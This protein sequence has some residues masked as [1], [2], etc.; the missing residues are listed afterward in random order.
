MEKMRGILFVSKMVWGLASIWKRRF[1]IARVVFYLGCGGWALGIINDM[2]VCCVGIF[3]NVKNTCLQKIPTISEP[4]L[5][6]VF[7]SSCRSHYAVSPF[8]VCLSNNYSRRHQSETAISTKLGTGE[9]CRAK[10]PQCDYPK[11]LHIKKSYM[12]VPTN[13]AAQRD[14]ETI[15]HEMLF[16]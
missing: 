16:H 1:R 10:I 8:C 2:F 9:R 13:N 4:M 12:H 3:G 6:W 7:Q 5:P 15:F 14:L 11:P